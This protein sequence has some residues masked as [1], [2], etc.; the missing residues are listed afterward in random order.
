MS[1]RSIARSQRF[2][3]LFVTGITGVLAI[4]LLAVPRPAAA[5]SKYGPL[6]DKFAFKVA[7]S[8]AK[9]ST[10]IRLDSE[11]LGQG[12]TLKFE[13][14]LGLDSNKLIPTFGFDWQ[15]AKRHKLSIRYQD[16]N[17]SATSQALKEIKWGDM[18]IPINSNVGLGYDIK[19]TFVD[20][21]YYPWVKDRWAAG[22]GIGFRVME[23]KATL[24]YTDEEHDISGSTEAKGTGPLPY[25]YFEYRRMLSDRWRFQTGL[26]WLSVKVGDIDGSQWVGRATF[27]YLLGDRWGFGGALN[28]ATI[29]VDWKGLENQEGQSVLK[30]SINMDVSDITFFAR[31]RF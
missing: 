24:S 9:L 8:F 11:T 5:Q 25:L 16:I 15:I 31:V 7:G 30:G 17:R 28:I 4:A 21:A 22:F 19:Q 3:Q 13:D 14:D 27:E 10:K 26:G 23:I 2:N 1:C 12:T 20:Y 29:D 6:F 18:V